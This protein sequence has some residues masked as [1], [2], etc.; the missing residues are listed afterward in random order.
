MTMV[1]ISGSDARVHGPGPDGEQ[2]SHILEIKMLAPAP[3]LL[4]CQATTADDKAAWIAL[5]GATYPWLGDPPPRPRPPLTCGGCESQTR[6]NRA[7]RQC[8]LRMAAATARV[9]LGTS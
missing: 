5:L 7:V 9:L 8:A 1:S 3:E 6:A 4:T 2:Q